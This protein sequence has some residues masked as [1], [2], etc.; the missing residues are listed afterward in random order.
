MPV[1]Y[2][3][4]M[5][6]D[7]AELLVRFPPKHAVHYGHHCTIRFQPSRGD[8]A[9]ITPGLAT[10]LN[11]LARIWD[12]KADVLLVEAPK[13]TKTFP[14]ITIS[15][16]AGTPPA[17]ADSLLERALH[18]PDTVQYMPVDGVTVD[19]LE[20]YFDGHDVVSPAS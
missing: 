14:H 7:S 19:V 1:I 13:S 8:V 12:N 3:A 16:R 9:A 2:T 17:Y 11:V 15:T 18:A 20:G 6:K 5:V 10:A 4:Y